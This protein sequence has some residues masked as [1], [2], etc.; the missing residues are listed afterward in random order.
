MAV[1]AV[2]MF[3]KRVRVLVQQGDT[4]GI[5]Y[6]AV[7][8][9]LHLVHPTVEHLEDQVVLVVEGQFQHQDVL[10]VVLH[11]ILVIVALMFT[12][13]LVLV[14]QVQDIAE[15]RYV[16]D[17]KPHHHVQPIAEQVLLKHAGITFVEAVKQRHHARLI[18]R[19]VEKDQYPLQD[20]SAVV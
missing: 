2:T 16:L 3:T 6:A 12:K 4:A 9:L 14:E 18:A 5:R 13:L 17:R 7:E 10:A 15:I 8:R 11:T 20:A 19:Y 1:I